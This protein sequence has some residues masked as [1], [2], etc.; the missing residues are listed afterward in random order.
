VAVT[1]WAHVHGLVSLQIC[2]SLDL[3]DEQFREVYRSSVKR[4][5]TGLAGG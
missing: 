2:G 1:V 4:L 3:T 5:V